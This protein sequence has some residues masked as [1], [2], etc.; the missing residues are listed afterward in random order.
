MKVIRLTAAQHALLK[1]MLDSAIESA[2]EEGHA[3]LVEMRGVWR[4]CADARTE[5]AFDHEAEAVGRGAR[6]S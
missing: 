1:T 4:A 3:L 2:H 6:T 5:P